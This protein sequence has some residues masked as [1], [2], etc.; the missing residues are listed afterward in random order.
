[1]G[2]MRTRTERYMDE[3][4]LLLRR[5]IHAPELQNAILMDIKGEMEMMRSKPEDN[6]SELEAERDKYRAMLEG[7][8]ELRLT[9]EAELLDPE[10]ERLERRRTELQSTTPTT[11]LLTEKERA[12][13]DRNNRFDGSKRT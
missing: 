13:F 10:L 4:L 12:I 6:I 3:K 1:M 5:Q 7:V 11:T 2:D 9:P 8:A